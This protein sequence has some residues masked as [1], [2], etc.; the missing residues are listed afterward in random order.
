MAVGPHGPNGHAHTS[1]ETRRECAGCLGYLVTKP[2]GRD[3]GIQTVAATVRPLE[4]FD[5]ETGG[6][7]DTVAF[8]SSRRRSK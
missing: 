1:T 2:L 8:F 7:V 4:Y 6:L 3:R 5:P